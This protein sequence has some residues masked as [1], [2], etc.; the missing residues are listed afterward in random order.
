[1][2]GKSITSTDIVTE[3]WLTTDVEYSQIIAGQVRTTSGRVIN[4]KREGT[5][6]FWRLPVAYNKV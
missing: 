4:R 5:I 2:V 6:L 1:M 3:T